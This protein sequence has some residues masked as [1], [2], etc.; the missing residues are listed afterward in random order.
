MV[1]TTLQIYQ[2]LRIYFPEEKPT[3]CEPQWVRGPMLFKSLVDE[4]KLIRNVR[5]FKMSE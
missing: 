5:H 4:P 2:K 3:I 1:V